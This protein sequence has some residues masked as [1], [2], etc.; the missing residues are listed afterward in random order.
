M[1]EITQVSSV[2][3]S[4][5]EAVEDPAGRATQWAVYAGETPVVFVMISDEV[6]P[7]SPAISR[8]TSGSS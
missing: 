3:D 4:M 2:D 8:T 1:R 7:D 5:I 6:A